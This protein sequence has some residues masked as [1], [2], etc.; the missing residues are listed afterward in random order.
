M[1]KNKTHCPKCEVLVIYYRA[2]VQRTPGRDVRCPNC[3][4]RFQPGSES[5]GTNNARKRSNDQE[6]RAAK[7]YGARVQPGSGSMAGAKADVRKEGELRVECKHTTGKSISIKQEWLRKVAKEASAGEVPV[8]EIE[9]QGTHPY[10]KYVVLRA[11]DYTS[12]LLDLEAMDRQAKRDW[13]KE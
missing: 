1:K 2:V 6:K 5:T 3:D 10:E 9:F 4:H 13:D 12:M 8:L 11:R 7:A